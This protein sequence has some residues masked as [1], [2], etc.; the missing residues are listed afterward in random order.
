MTKTRTDPGLVAALL[1][2][3]SVKSLARKL[4]LTNSAVSQWAKVPPHLVLQVEKATGVSR[5]KLRPDLYGARAPRP[6]N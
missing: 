3:G 2:A 1:V 6:S 5:Y 4:R